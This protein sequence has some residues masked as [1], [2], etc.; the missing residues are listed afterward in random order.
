MR[1]FNASV[2]FRRMLAGRL[3]TGRKLRA[4]AERRPPARHRR[5]STTPARVPA[6]A[7]TEQP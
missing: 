2:W 1:S 4:T 5:T 6:A 7:R 3:L